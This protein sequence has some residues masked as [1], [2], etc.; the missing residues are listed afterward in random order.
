[1]DALA[2]AVTAVHASINSFRE[3]NRASIASLHSILSVYGQR[4]TD[5]EDGLNEFDKRLSS[6]GA[7]KE[8]S[9]AKENDALREKVAYLENYTRRQNIRIVGISENMEG[10][11]PTEFI[12]KLLIHRMVPFQEDSAVPVEENTD[13]PDYL[14]EEEEEEESPS[15]EQDKAVTPPRNISASNIS[16]CSVIDR[17]HR[18][19]IGRE[20]IRLRPIGCEREGPGASEQLVWRLLLALA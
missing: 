12:T 13:I 10:P 20:C 16:S 7:A 14:P 6:V 4:I 18:R 15:Q 5:I 17:Q 1:M 11:R 19:P 8:T 2:N 9:L 3:E